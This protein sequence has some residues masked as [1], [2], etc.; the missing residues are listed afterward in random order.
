MNPLRGIAFKLISVSLFMAMAAFVKATAEDVPP[1]EAMFF[2]AAFAL[3]VTLIWLR[4]RGEFP[5]GLRTKNPL[6]HVWRGLVGSAAMA[7][8]FFAL[9]L[10][11]LPEVVAIG[12][13]AP[14]L[15]TIFAAMFL[16]E[17]IR[18]YRMFAVALG[19]VGV[20]IIV[21]P[22]LSGIDAG[23]ATKLETVGA[24][25]ALLSATLA[26]LAQVF[27]RKLTMTEATGAIVFWFS[28]TTAALSLLTA[29]FG[30]VMPS[31]GVFA[32]LVAAGLFG[33]LGQIFLTMGY[34][35]AETAVI[36]PFDYAQMLFALVIGW[37]VFAEAPTSLTLAGAA[38][39]T[40]AGLLIIWRERRLGIE[41]RLARKVMTPQG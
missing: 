7:F 36:A 26:A 2:R 19:L 32:M 31:A 27:V 3:P 16:G 13:A 8:G 11:P 18:A 23:S 6:G 29:P 20:V 35:H 24:F 37:F 40:S 15:A 21:W 30:W 25:A 12:F 10:L 41:R 14:I 33:G 22:R 28:L 1:G 38:L 34:R 5:V 9:G 39:T 17:T 4:A